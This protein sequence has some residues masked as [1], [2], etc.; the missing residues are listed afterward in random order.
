MCFCVTGSL[1]KQYALFTVKVDR[2]RTLRMNM[3]GLVIVGNA[4]DSEN[5][6]TMSYNTELRKITIIQID[7][8]LKTWQHI[9]CCLSVKYKPI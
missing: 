7:L 5:I 3:T 9:F 1:D 2:M 4:A 8:V 6:N